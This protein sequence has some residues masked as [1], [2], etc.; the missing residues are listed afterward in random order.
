MRTDG[1]PKNHGEANRYSVHIFVANSLELE[2]NN[3]MSHSL[4]S[5]MSICGCHLMMVILWKK[6]SSKIV[7]MNFD[8]LMAVTMKITVS[9]MQFSV[10]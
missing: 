4:H 9:G 6:M 2:I 8:I 1:Q 10:V 3:S 5:H 7:S